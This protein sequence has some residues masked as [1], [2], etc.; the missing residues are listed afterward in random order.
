MVTGYHSQIPAQKAWLREDAQKWHF[1]LM[2][3]ESQ[4]K[5]KKLEW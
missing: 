1:F 5:S 3:A 2:D 4:R